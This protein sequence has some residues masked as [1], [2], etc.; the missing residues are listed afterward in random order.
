MSYTPTLTSIFA[1]EFG[2]PMSGVLHK[3]QSSNIG[4]LTT[5]ASNVALRAVGCENTEHETIPRRNSPFREY[6][7][8]FGGEF[9]FLKTKQHPAKLA[10]PGGRRWP[11]LWRRCIATMISD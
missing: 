11:S 7:S 1:T 4:E 2:Y 6:L 5:D 3:S 8:F 9:A 10:S